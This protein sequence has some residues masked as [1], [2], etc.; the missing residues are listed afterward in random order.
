MSGP[1]RG[2]PE[3][4]VYVCTHVVT[5]RIY[6]SVCV[7]VFLL[8]ALGCCER[9]CAAY[10]ANTGDVCAASKLSERMHVCEHHTR[11]SIGGC[12]TVRLTNIVTMHFMYNVCGQRIESERER[13]CACLHHVNAEVGR[14]RAKP[15]PATVGLYTHTHAYRQAEAASMRI[16]VCAVHVPRA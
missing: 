11:L 13:V 14:L 7:C 15:Q 1:W 12:S 9:V 3:H 5:A 4:G 6:D 2:A 10:A 16:K 8:F